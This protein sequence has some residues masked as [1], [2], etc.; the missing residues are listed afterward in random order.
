MKLLTAL[1]FLILPGSVM[2][3]GGNIPLNELDFLDHIKAFDKLQIL[4][5]LGKPSD[6]TDIRN[7]VTGDEIGTIWH[8]HYL[9]TSENGDYYKTTE[10]DFI[11][12]RVVMVV[13][14]NSDVMGNNTPTVPYETVMPIDRECMVTC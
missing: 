14:M 3:E 4:E 6:T 7:V 1:L 10:L 12:D 2:A 9:N 8:Y 5:I 11:G 13:F